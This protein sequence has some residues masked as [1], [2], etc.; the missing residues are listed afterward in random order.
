MT[1]ANVKLSKNELELVCD[2][3]FI[4]TKNRIIEKV[5][6]L[7]GILSD[8]FTSETKAAG[9]VY[10]TPVQTSSPKIYKGEN[11]K[12]LPYVML[13]YPRYFVKEDAFAI[14]CFFW[15]GNFFSITLYVAGTY[16]ITYTPVILNQLS[17]KGN[18]DWYIC[19]N[20]NRWEHHFAEDNYVLLTNPKVSTLGKETV[21]NDKS[22][23]KIAS[24]IPL[25]RWDDAHHFFVSR[26]K[27]IIE[28]VDIG[29]R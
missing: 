28:M 5:Y 9:N 23:F 22:F 20:E 7:F 19:V 26:Y 29:N 16:A 14:R 1:H 2:E 24:K 8:D 4:L 6:N 27:E 25:M 12:G 15:W 10:P 21:E 13:D 17:K 3:Q 11:Y 18:L